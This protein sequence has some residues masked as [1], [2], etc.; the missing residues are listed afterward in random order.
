[1]NCCRENGGNTHMHS[2][3]SWRDKRVAVWGR[4]IENPSRLRRSRVAAPS[5]KQHPGIIIS[6][7]TQATCLAEPRNAEMG[8]LWIEALVTSR[9]AYEAFR[10]FT[11]SFL[12]A[13]RWYKV[14]LMVRAIAYRLLSAIIVYHAPIGL[15]EVVPDALPPL[16]CLT[17]LKLWCAVA[18]QL[19]EHLS[20]EFAWLSSRGTT[21]L[22]ASLR[23]KTNQFIIFAR[24]FVTKRDADHINGC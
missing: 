3:R 8:A 10:R 23:E 6:P 19:H 11:S 18:T 21:N 12:E 4:P 17:S 7:A 13:K 16:S 9:F 20:L 5:P 2:L 15:H 14:L 22:L 1:M 24:L